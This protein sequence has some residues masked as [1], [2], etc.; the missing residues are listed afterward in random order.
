L[1]NCVLS[2]ICILDHTLGY[3]DLILVAPWI[4]DRDEPLEGLWA[5]G[6]ERR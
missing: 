1:K 3:P 6:F 4:L 2:R 5:A